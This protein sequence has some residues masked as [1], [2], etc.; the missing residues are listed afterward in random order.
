MRDAWT[1]PAGIS[2]SDWAIMRLPLRTMD[3]IRAGTR[4]EGRPGTPRC[5]R[6]RMTQQPF[7]VPKLLMVFAGDKACRPSGRLHPSRSSDPMDVI[8]R[9]VRQIEID[10]MAD[11][12]DV[13]AASCDIRRDKHSKVPRLN[14]S[15]PPAAATDSG[16]RAGQRLCVHLPIMR[17]RRSARC[18]VLVN[19]STVSFSSSQERREI[20]LASW[21]VWWTA[22]RH[23]VGRRGRGVTI[24]RTGC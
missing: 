16:H 22:L 13:N 23:A 10:H 24:T 1:H 17:P 9:T 6:H 12:G 8:L 21:E 11:V 20:T 2:V 19:T 5:Q 18:F 15:R 4:I 7:D 3:S 14:P